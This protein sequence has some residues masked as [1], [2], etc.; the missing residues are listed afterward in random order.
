MGA[1]GSGITQDDT[2]LDLIEDF[3]DS[4]KK[5][6]NIEITTKLLIE[7]N[8][9]LIDDEDEGPLF[10]I[11]LAKCQWEYGNLQTD[12]LEK[13]ID[14]FEKENG[15]GIWKEESQKDYLARKKVI[16][17]FIENIKHTNPKPKKLPKLT[18]R[19]PLFK[20]GDCLSIKVNEHY[21]GA[22]IV[23]KADDS[24]PEYGENLIIAT[25]YWNQVPPKQENFL[26]KEWLKLTYENWNGSVHKSWYGPQGF[27][28]YKDV[29]V[30]VGSID[31]SEFKEIPCESYSLWSSLIELIGRQMDS[32]DSKGHR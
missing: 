2:V 8:K 3:K 4:V 11:A 18:I 10:W 32:C 5:T 12:V 23:I 24:D 29:I 30:K 7:N 6:K 19:K 22:A 17:N 28:K 15:L 9:Y 31:V 13:V 27:R 20:E 14:D 26:K 1:W 16:M 21:Y 25:T